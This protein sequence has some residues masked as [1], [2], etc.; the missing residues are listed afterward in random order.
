MRAKHPSEALLRSQVS[1]R[2]VE[3]AANSGKE[4]A[5]DIL[6]A[7]ILSTYIASTALETTTNSLP[8]PNNVWLPNSYSEAMT[9]L[10]IWSGPIEKELKVMRDRS[11]WEEVD[12]PPDVHTIGTCWTFTKKYDSSGDCK[13]TQSLATNSGIF[14]N[15]NSKRTLSLQ[16]SVC[17]PTLSTT[18]R[19]NSEPISKF[20]P[21]PI[22]IL[23][24]NRD[25]NSE[26]LH[27]R[28]VQTSDLNLE[29]DP[30][31]FR[32]RHHRSICLPCLV[33]VMVSTHCSIFYCCC[34]YIAQDLS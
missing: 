5:T 25:A 21:K 34:L 18:P 17:P 7:S 15:Q 2:D 29:M 4:W 6:T 24:S 19:S 33:M 14:P 1:E 10:E 13:G 26:A 23:T 22:S 3:E 30:K 11:V 32:T 31:L 12:P 8:D 9:Q 27:A 20:I 16:N 28:Q